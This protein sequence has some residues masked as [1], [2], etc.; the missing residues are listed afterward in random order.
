MGVP[1]NSASRALRCDDDFLARRRP[2]GQAEH[3]APVAFVHHAFADEIVVL[4]MVHDDEAEHA[5]VFQRAAHDLVVLDA[6]AVVGERD[7]AG[8]CKRADRREFLAGEAFGDRA[9]GEDIHARLGARFF[10]DPR[11][12]RSGC[13]PAGEVFGMQTTV[14]KPPAAAARVP[15]AMVSFADWPGSR[16]WTWMSMSPGATTRPR[17]SIVS[18]ARKSGA[19]RRGRIDDAAIDEEQ[20][21]RVR[22]GRSPG[23]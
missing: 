19:L 1:V 22:R 16:R 4:A 15:L 7:D 23:R 6:M 13:P 21:A 18:S 10:L 5:R 11:R 17:A 20:I 9:G 2:A 12:P 8:L 14:V 3:G